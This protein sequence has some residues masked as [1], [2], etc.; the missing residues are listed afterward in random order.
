MA[1]RDTHIKLSEKYTYSCKYKQVFCNN[2]P[3][4]LSNKESHLLS[5]LINA[6]GN[7]VSFQEIEYAIWEESVSNGALRLLIH[8]LRNKLDFDLIETFYGFGCR[9]NVECEA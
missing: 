2:L 3:V 9:L 5:I 8:R 4:K 7:V 6:R 1:K